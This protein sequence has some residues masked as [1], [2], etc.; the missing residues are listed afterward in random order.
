MRVI[1]AEMNTK[2]NLLYEMF[3]SDNAEDLEIRVKNEKQTFS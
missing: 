3:L 1:A 2:D